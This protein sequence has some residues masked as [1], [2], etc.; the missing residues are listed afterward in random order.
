VAPLVLPQKAV[1]PIGFNARRRV[2]EFLTEQETILFNRRV[3]I[4]KEMKILY[5]D[6]WYINQR[7][8]FLREQLAE[9]SHH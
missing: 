8:K 9:L 5:A 3:D 4:K 6:R 1:F 7:L 2:V